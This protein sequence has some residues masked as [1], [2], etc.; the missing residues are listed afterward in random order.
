MQ[1]N[2]LFFSPIFYAVIV[3]YVFLGFA[4]I[5]MGNQIASYLFSED[6]YFENIGAISLFAASFMMFYA[7]FHALKSRT[8]T[9]M[10]W[11]KQ[12]AYLGLALLF[13]FG[14]GEEIS[15]GQR[16]FNIET[17]PSLQE[18]N[19]QDEITVH[20]IE[21]NGQ[22]IPFEFGF[23]VFWGLYIVLIP[24][25]LFF[26]LPLRNFTEKFL[27]IVH[28]GL[29]GLFITNYLMAKVSFL[30]FSETY[31]FS[32]VPLI[33]AVQEVKESNYEFF[34]ALVCLYLLWD[35]FQIRKQ[36]AMQSASTGV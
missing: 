34:Y 26:S 8:L 15:W 10:S 7:F 33:Q 35:L 1:K 19:E 14:A 18:I 24:F 23:D 30:L 3:V 20:N 6:H 31:T 4:T 32:G 12:L 22:D 16:I 9:K 28:W 2:N 11:I 36:V 21:I 17:P 29:G 27:P 13:L 5:G 25:V